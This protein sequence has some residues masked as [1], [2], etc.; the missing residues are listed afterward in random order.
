MKVVHVAGKRKRAIARATAREGNGVI[1]MNRQLIDTIEPEMYRLRL[2]EPL[3][4]A[5]D[6]AGK[7]DI[8]VNVIGGGASGQVEAAR[9]AIARALVEFS[10]KDVLKN[11]FLEYDRNLLVADVRRKE[12]RK[13]NDSKAR[14]KRQKSYR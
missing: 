12:T 10:G 14:A 6:L 5:G 2:R 8:S 3:L 4:L 13:P 9:L 11:K 1:R 7:V